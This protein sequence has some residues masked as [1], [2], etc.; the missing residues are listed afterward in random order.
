[1]SK[2][3][4]KA[5]LIKNRCENVRVENVDEIEQKSENKQEQERVLGNKGGEEK[6]RG[7]NRE[8]DNTSLSLS[9]IS[10]LSLHQIYSKFSWI[11][12]DVIFKVFHNCPISVQ[13]EL[14]Q[15]AVLYLLESV[16]NYDESRGASFSTYAW[17]YIR[18]KILT[19]MRDSFRTQGARIA[20][21]IWK[22]ESS[23][24]YLSES[25]RYDLIVDYCK[26]VGIKETDVNN[27][28]STTHISY[29]D[30]ETEDYISDGMSLEHDVV[31]KITCESILDFILGYKD[32]TNSQIKKNIIDN[33][34]SCLRK[35]IKFNYRI[36]SEKCN[37]SKQMVCDTLNKIKS[38][39][40]AWLECTE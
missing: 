26:N 11:P 4:D 8:K 32:R 36:C 17:Q 27:V 21:I 25:D 38:E 30:K 23:H 14:Y 19:K 37:C 9:S 5:V 39:L 28:Y 40:R 18:F 3:G 24:D 16:K 13:E 1:M 15:D 22:F 35:D 34:V 29:L 2:F 31:D 6:E 33:W 12:H 7:D 20:R 10:L